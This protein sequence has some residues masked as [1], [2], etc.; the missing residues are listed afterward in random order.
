MSISFNSINGY[1]PPSASDTSAD[2]LQDK[3]QGNMAGATDDEL[4]EVCKEFEAYFTEQMFKAM[5]KMVPESEETDQSMGQLKDYFEEQMLQ[6]YAKQSS[7]GQGLGIAQMMYEQ[8][9]RNYEI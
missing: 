6:E 3:I 9:K 4:M 2:R 1:I 8:M 5:R 7:E